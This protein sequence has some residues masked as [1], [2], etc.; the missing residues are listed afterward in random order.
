[1]PHTALAE[2]GDRVVEVFQSAYHIPLFSNEIVS[3]LEVNFPPGR[4]CDFHHHRYDSLNI[5]LVDYPANASGQA[6]GGPVTIM[7]DGKPMPKRGEVN[8][9]EYSSKPIINRG[10]NR[11]NT[12]M[13]LIEIH[14]TGN[15]VFGYSPADRD[16]PAYIK[17]LDNARAKA[18]RLTLNPGESA[19]AITQK[20]PGMRVVIQGGEISEGYPGMS[21]RGM[22]LDDGKVYWQG[23]SVVRTIKNI[24]ATQVTVVEVEFK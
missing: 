1:M 10:I 19:T 15:R 8:F 20:A 7:R 24:G 14:F 6:Y 13:R 16:D 18:W 22:W 11:G 17:V 2:P 4:E 21:D 5:Y 12:P 23:P 3:V 9:N